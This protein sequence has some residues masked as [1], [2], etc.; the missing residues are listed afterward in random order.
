ML[1]KFR[2]NCIET[3]KHTDDPSLLAIMQQLEVGV[4]FLS[5]KL[6]IKKHNE[7]AASLLLFNNKKLIGKNLTGL[8]TQLNIELTK[9]LKKLQDNNLNTISFQTH[10]LHGNRTTIVKWVILKR[11]KNNPEQKTT[12]YIVFLNEINELML[13]TLVAKMPGNVYWKDKTGRYLGCNENTL[14]RFDATSYAD[15]IGKSDYELMPK[16]R[17][18]SIRSVDKKVMLT[19]QTMVVEEIKIIPPIVHYLSHK[20]PLQNRQ[21]DVI[22]ILGISFNINDRKQMEQK[23]HRAKVRAEKAEQKLHQLLAQMHQEITGETTHTVNNP[24][25]HA[26]NLRYYLENIINEMPGNVYWKAK[27]GRFLGCNNNTLQLFNLTS[28][29]QL[30]GKTD[31][32]LLG[33]NLADPIREIDLKILAQDREQL[34]E[35]V[36]AGN[37][38][39]Y[40]LS[41]KVPLHNQKGEVIGLLGISFDITE[42]K[43]IEEQLKQAQIN[44]ERQEERL[45]GM[46]LLA[47]ALAHEVRNPIGAILGVCQRHAYIPAVVEGYELAKQHNLPVKLI[48]QNNLERLRLGDQ[49]IIEIANS[50]NQMI[51]L[52]LNNIRFI[53]SGVKSIEIYSIAECVQETLDA[54]PFRSKTERGLILFNAEHDFQFLG[55]KLLVKHILQNFLKNALFYMIGKKMRVL[56]FGWRIRK[57]LIYCILKIRVKAWARSAQKK[58]LNVFLLKQKMEQVWGWL[59]VNGR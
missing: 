46:K 52:L 44:K 19:N 58:Y 42:R 17:A 43:H 2:E 53:E 36:K 11:A 21:G 33:K 38:P 8:S 32:E 29:S 45:Q 7:N 35:E 56:V 40:F 51:N 6:V 50:A 14:K 59:F 31:Y 5:Q 41:Q 9:A 25:E 24:E 49:P 47:A 16:E 48:R 4:L 55:S 57:I 20:V 15:V 10:I 22:G 13:E 34:I 18:D 54:Y 1:N 3:T 28:K 37:P 23:L 39:I 30:I 12:P 26:I 27:D